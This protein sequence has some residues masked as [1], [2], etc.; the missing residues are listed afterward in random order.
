MAITRAQQAKQMLQ[1]GG[2]IGFFTAGL[3]RGEN[4]SPGTS[5]TGGMRDDNEAT[6]GGPPGTDVVTK[7]PVKDK[8]GDETQ[9]RLDDYREK[10]I[11]EPVKFP[12]YTPSY[13]K[14][15]EG[16]LSKG[17]AVTRKFNFDKV[18]KA[19]RYQ[20]TD[21]VTG[22]TYTFDQDLA[23][24]NPE[25][26]EAANKQLLQDRNAGKVDAFGNPKTRFD[27]DSNDNQIL[28]PQQGIMTQAPGDMNQGTETEEDEGLRLAFRADG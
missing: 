19:G 5:T 21:P 28:F 11:N 20:Y 1:D 23:L 10:F 12:K 3:A 15:L 16:P 4:I 13:L 22:K 25:I 14:I 6:R 26:F 17:Q 9:K 18:A 24:E 2:R 7:P 27:D 8:Y